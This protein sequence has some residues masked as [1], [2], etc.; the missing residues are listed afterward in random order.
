HAQGAKRVAQVPNRIAGGGF[1][2]I[3]TRHALH[4]Q[5]RE[6][7]FLHKLEQRLTTR[8]LNYDSGDYIVRVA[9]LPLAARLKVERLARPPVHD[10]LRGDRLEHHWHYVIL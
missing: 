4:P 7:L 8:P 3:H 9:V 10:S 6:Y 5:R 1:G 2:D